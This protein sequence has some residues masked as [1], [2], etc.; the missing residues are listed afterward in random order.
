MEGV[1]HYGRAAGGHW[2][3]N[4]NGVAAALASRSAV[5]RRTSGATYCV[6]PCSRCCTSGGRP[7]RCPRRRWRASA[8]SATEGRA[9]RARARRRAGG[10]CLEPRRGRLVAC[11]RRA[12]GRTKEQAITPR[13]VHRVRGAG[14]RRL[15]GARVP[16]SVIKK[17]GLE[18]LERRTAMDLKDKWRNLL[19]SRRCRASRAEK[20]RRPPS[21][22]RESCGW[23]RSL[24][25]ARR[26]GR[27][28]TTRR[29]RRRRR[30]RDAS[31]SPRPRPRP[32]R[33]SLILKP[34]VPPPCFHVTAV[35]LNH[36]ASPL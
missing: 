17:L 25:A 9:A 2:S 8:S 33:V 26:K 4:A 14:G 7:R 1:A 20:R 5:D 3:L 30:R 23:R 18:N 11:S 27:K 13:D 29:P 12:Q 31:F 6:L 21:S 19:Q 28:V 35:R 22:C 24:A 36:R 15:R 34:N 32:P 16:R 10:G